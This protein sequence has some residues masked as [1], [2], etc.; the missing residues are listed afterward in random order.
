M[1]PPLEPPR[2]LLTNRIDPHIA[3]QYDEIMSSQWQ[4]SEIVLTSFHGARK[5]LTV[6]VTQL[7]A[8]ALRQ[9]VLIALRWKQEN[10]SRHGRSTTRQTRAG[11]IEI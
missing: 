8:S 4:E 9:G 3:R 10:E 7:D 1:R 5:H 6:L 11:E 2:V